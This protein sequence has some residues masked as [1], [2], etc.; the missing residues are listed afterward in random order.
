MFLDYKLELLKLVK[1]LIIRK[2]LILKILLFV[3]YNLEGHCI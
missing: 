3:N 1:S 2:T